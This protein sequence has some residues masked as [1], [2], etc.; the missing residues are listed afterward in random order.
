ML[1]KYHLLGLYVPKNYEKSFQSL[2][3]WAL[4]RIADYHL[5]QIGAK[6]NCK[7]AL[8]NYQR[9]EAEL[10]DHLLSHPIEAKAGIMKAQ[11]GQRKARE[12]L[13]AKIFAEE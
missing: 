3:K 2:V 8:N 10:Y 7:F 1:R 6:E 4:L 9:A 5:N 11:E 13:E 12:A